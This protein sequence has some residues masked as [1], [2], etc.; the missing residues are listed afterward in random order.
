LRVKVR[1]ATVVPEVFFSVKV[2][3]AVELLG[4]TMAMPVF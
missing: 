1:V 2:R 3:V 4:F